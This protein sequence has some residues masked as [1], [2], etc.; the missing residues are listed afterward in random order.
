MKQEEQRKIIDAL[1][2]HN[3]VNQE[4][5]ELLKDNPE[6]KDKEAL[7]EAYRK[8]ADTNELEID[9]IKQ[10]D[11]LGSIIEEYIIESQLGLDD[12]NKQKLWGKIT[13]KCQELGIDEQKRDHMIQEEKKMLEEDNEIVDLSMP[14]ESELELFALDEMELTPDDEL[15]NLL[16]AEESELEENLSN[17][18]DANVNDL[19]EKIEIN[20][21][22]NEE[23]PISKYNAVFTNPILT[24]ADENDL[25]QEDYT[26]EIDENKGLW[27]RIKNAFLKVK[28]VIQQKLNI[29]KNKKLKGQELLDTAEKNTPSTDNKIGN[30]NSWELS[31]FG[32]TAEEVQVNTQKAINNSPKNISNKNSNIEIVS[33]QE[34]NI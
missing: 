20:Q 29:N 11:E 31:Q 1:K 26:M 15:D 4:K 14:E 5:D 17:F 32:T 7:D 21:Q 22:E 34:I 30:T 28:N 13:K 3:E 24:G 8:V 25:K 19:E 12:K 18:F 9:E 27:N 33:D 2:K 6:M 10:Y 23:Q 16:T